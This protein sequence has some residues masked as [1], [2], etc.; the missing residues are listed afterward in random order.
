[1]NCNKFKKWTIIDKNRKKV[2]EY[3][4]QKNLTLSNFIWTVELFIKNV[5][6]TDLELNGF[7]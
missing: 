2:N 4:N 3:I 5:N 6:R 1:M 7:E